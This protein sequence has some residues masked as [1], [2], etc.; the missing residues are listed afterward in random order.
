MKKP[1]VFLVSMLAILC[2]S[3]NRNQESDPDE[4]GQGQ[5]G[6][7]AEVGF[8][9]FVHER[10]VTTFK[11]GIFT[12]DLVIESDFEGEAFILL[13]LR[14]PSIPENDPNYDR[15][16][17]F[18]GF[19]NDVK[20]DGYQIRSYH[21]LHNQHRWF[22]FPSLYP[23]SGNECFRPLEPTFDFPVFIKKITAPKGTVHEKINIRLPDGFNW[24]WGEVVAFRNN[25]AFEESMK[26]K[27]SRDI[28]IEKLPDYLAL[29]KIYH[30]LDTLNFDKTPSSLYQQLFP[31]SSMFSFLTTNM[32]ALFMYIE[33]DG[34][35]KIVTG[36]YGNESFLVRTI[37]FSYSIPFGVPYIKDDYYDKYIPLYEDIVFFSY[38]G[39]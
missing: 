19:G 11:D 2:F 13:A 31:D 28:L 15:C 32:G 16:V 17:P 7:P 36:D 20:V 21:Q 18:R 8:S 27:V 29:E 4:P 12:V 38:Y 9:L 14:R 37:G 5:Y 30:L 24:C 10:P 33:D 6:R 1:F 23:L 22:F 39:W 25:K 34:Y 35:E 3:C 26:Y